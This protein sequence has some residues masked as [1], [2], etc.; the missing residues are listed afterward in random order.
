M[1]TVKAETAPENVVFVGS[2]PPMNYILA[3]V[4][5][6]NG[7]SPN[8]VLRARG[9]AISRAV[10]VAELV[11]NKF[12]EKCTVESVRIGTERVTDEGRRSVNVSSIEIH[13]AKQ[14]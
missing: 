5:L 10:D 6:F 4:T 1:S 2:K 14:A 13:L 3:V 7:G 11:R 9:K 8:V 12:V